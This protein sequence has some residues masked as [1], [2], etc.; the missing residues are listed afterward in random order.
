MKIVAFLCGL[1]YGWLA[2]IAHAQVVR[3]RRGERIREQVVSW[4]NGGGP[5]A[6]WYASHYGSPASA[7]WQEMVH[8]A[9]NLPFSDEPL[10]DEDAELPDWLTGAT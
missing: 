3:R 9:D 8:T 5:P 1:F 6:Q 4:L 2:C 7:G 10:D